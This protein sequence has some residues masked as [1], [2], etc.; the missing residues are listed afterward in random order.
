[1]P[2]TRRS[3]YAAG[4][5]RSGARFREVMMST[6]AVPSIA[7][8]RRLLP[9]VGRDPHEAG[10]A[11]TPLEL[12]FDLTFVIAFGQA[13]NQLSHLL[14]E[15]HIAPALGG[16]SFAMLAIVLAWINFSWFAS[17]FDTDDWAFRLATMVQMV[18]VLILALG[19]PAMFHSLDTGHTLDNRVVVAGYVVMRVAMLFQWLRAAGRNP[20][21]RAAC[22][23]NVAYITVAQVG[24][25][26]VLFLDQSLPVALLCSGVL[27]LVEFGGPMLAESRSGGTPWHAH[28]ISE[29]YS[30]LAIIALGEGLIGTIAS[31]SAVIELQ[32]WT[33][34]TVLVAVAGTGIT[35]GLWWVYFLAP[36]GEVL[37]RFRNRGFLWGYGH[38]VLF[39]AI[40]A[41]GAGLHVAAYVLEDEATIGPVG[42]LLATAVPVGVFLIAATALDSALMRTLD[43]MRLA[44]LTGALIIL[45]L[46]V[47]AAAAGLSIGFCL[48]I[49]MCAP[50]VMIVGDEAGGHRRRSIRLERALVA[51]S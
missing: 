12:L 18:G 5:T 49:V 13:G 32:G 40:A 36:A 30:L 51:S 9:M 47:A 10:R 42:A 17:A 6:A 11:S 22:L 34:E 3:Q 31:V 29:R 39:A 48:M 33:L 44:L 35:F 27:F 50:V 21:R 19:L 14:A 8:R 43:A 4:R 25:I 15:G 28:H 24:W 23:T 7:R 41:V 45:A 46:A 20:D 16:F 1:M 2:E 38:I 37:H 26:A